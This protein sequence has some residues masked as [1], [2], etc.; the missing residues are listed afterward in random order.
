MTR[1]SESAIFGIFFVMSVL[2]DYNSSQHDYITV[3]VM[4]SKKIFEKIA[5]FKKMAFL[6]KKF[7]FFCRV[8]VI[9]RASEIQPGARTV[10]L[11]SNEIPTSVEGKQR[12]P[13][14]S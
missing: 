9:F 7:G 2:L 13:A 6:S 1:H 4:W 3:V 5:F 8:R 10:L 12:S 14:G 11:S